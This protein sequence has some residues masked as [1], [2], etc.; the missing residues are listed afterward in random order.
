M[1]LPL[2]V[3]VLLWGRFPFVKRLVRPREVTIGPWRNTWTGIIG[4]ALTIAVG[5]LL[6]VTAGTTEVSGILGASNQADERPEGSGE[7][8]ERYEAGD[9]P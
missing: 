1:A 4:G 9:E 3:L 2:M 8:P 6:L 5:A 7:Y